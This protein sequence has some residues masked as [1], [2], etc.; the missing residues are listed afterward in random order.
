M[1]LVVFTGAAFQM[2]NTHRY[3][4]VTW[5]QTWTWKVGLGNVP[6]HIVCVPV[7]KVWRGWLLGLRVCILSAVCHSLYISSCSVK[8]SLS[9]S[10]SVWVVLGNKSMLPPTSH[11]Q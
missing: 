6:V 2:F 10:H 1:P 9:F 7:P 11:M 5:W 4:K 8:C 3:R